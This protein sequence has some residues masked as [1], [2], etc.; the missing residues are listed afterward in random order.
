MPLMTLP[1]R[2]IEHRGPVVMHRVQ[3]LVRNE[4]LLLELEPTNKF[5]K[6]AIKVICRKTKLHLGYIPAGNALA[7]G[8]KIKD[9]K[10]SIK[11]TFFKG[12]MMKLKFHK[13][14]IIADLL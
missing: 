13:K 4:V 11:C 12:D 2:G 9:P 7:I 8:K 3:R 10:V 6:N 14:T 1:I 5:D